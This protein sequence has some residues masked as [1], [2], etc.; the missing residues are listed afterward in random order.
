MPY[1]IVVPLLIA[2]WATPFVAAQEAEDALSAVRGQNAISEENL[3]TIRSF[4]TENVGAIVGD[5]PLAAQDAFA[6]L[7]AAYTGSDA[8]KKAYATACTEAVRAA[9]GRADLVPAS[10]LITLVGTL[11]AVDTLPLLLEAIQ[12][13]RV[14]VRAAAAIGLDRLRPLLAGSGDDAQTRAIDALSTVGK[15]E[16]SRVTLRA[17]YAAMSYGGG[18]NAAGVKRAAVALL[19]VLEERARQ[20]DSGELHAAG[21][22]DVGLRVAA[23]LA[24]S[25]DADER[26]RLTVATAKMIKYAIERYTSGRKKLADVRDENA[27]RQLLQLRNGMERLIETGES[28][29][30]TLL[31]P[32]GDR[33]EVIDAM[34]N[35]D[36][37]G[38]KNEWKKWGDLLQNSVGQNFA[39]VEVAEPSDD[40]DDE[41]EG[42]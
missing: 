16:R 36:V 26:K 10:R 40:S 5:D 29:L 37:I 1:R 41:S 8:F 20:Y 18:Q 38:M 35:L 13:E 15:Q 39:L 42:T 21:A 30:G 22:D 28:L 14:G 17:V 19:E 32:P 6:R 7:R 23:R 25:L 11:D 33:P 31:S 24:T 4:L 34:R 9:Y 2:V 27:N 3:G 12:D